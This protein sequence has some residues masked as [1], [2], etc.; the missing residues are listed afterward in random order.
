ME[1]AKPKLRFLRGQQLLCH[2]GNTQEMFAVC[3]PR[4][5]DNSAMDGEM[6]MDS[7]S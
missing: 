6:R 5:I 7:D 4:R 3:L 2:C 1:G